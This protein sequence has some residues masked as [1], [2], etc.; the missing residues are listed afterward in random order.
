LGWRDLITL[1]RYRHRTKSF[2]S[3]LTLTR[4]NPVGFFAFLAN[5]NPKNDIFTGVARK[6][7][8]EPPIIGQMRC[9]Q[10][11]RVA[12]LT[13]L[14]PNDV[15]DSLALLSLLDGL[16]VQAGERGAYCV[17]A[18]VDEGDPLFES[19]RKA[20]FAV[21]GWQR[22]YNMPFKGRVN[23]D[24]PSLWEL[25][26]PVAEPG[27][28]HLYQSLVPPLMQVANPLPEDRLFGLY[29]QQD[30]EMLAYVESIYGPEGIY[31]RPLIHPDLGNVPQLLENLEEHL[32][33]LLGRKVYL[34]VRSHQAWLENALGDVEVLSA[35]RQ[36]LMVKH[37]ALTQRVP[38]ANSRL[39][40]FEETG[41]EPTTSII[42]NLSRESG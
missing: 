22:I 34:A 8:N 18:E 24:L 39:A 20:G 37:L 1:Y 35:T 19:L 2:D 42:K 13:F 25:V 15:Q 36:A 16:V 41:A 38:L 17:L 29:H 32:S 9:N 40:M 5:F 6:A 11:R 31:L 12:N 4:G 3:A 10:G 27:I 14:V 26:T 7:K 21:Y 33:P 30:G 28:R 23:Y